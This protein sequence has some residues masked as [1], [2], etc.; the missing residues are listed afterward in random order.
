MSQSAVFDYYYD[1]HAEAYSFYKMPKVLFTD[2]YFR[3]VSC[4]AKVLYGLMLDRMS[5][6]RHNRW[7][8]DQG[9]VY[10]IFSVDDV[11]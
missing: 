1:M 6:S 11:Y 2:T 9:R 7:I 10:I 8:D 3:E 5:L 4:E